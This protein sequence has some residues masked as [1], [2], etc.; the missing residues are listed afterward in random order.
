MEE[1]SVAVE[2]VDAFI[3]AWTRVLHAAMVWSEIPLA[4]VDVQFVWQING[5]HE[6]EITGIEMKNSMLI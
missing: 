5:I 4:R 6:W 3:G 1:L 2:H